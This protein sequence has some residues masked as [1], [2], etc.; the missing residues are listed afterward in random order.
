MTPPCIAVVDDDRDLLELVDV[1]LRMGGYDSIRFLTS[2]DASSGMKDRQP[3]LA[4]VDL[5]LERRGAGLEVVEA[6]RNDP[7]TAHIPI[8]VW[9]SDREVATIVARRTLDGVVVRIKPVRPDELLRLITEL[10]PTT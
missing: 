2:L 9:S 7:A 5:N 3:A 1:V 10:L 6:L 4:I 8:I